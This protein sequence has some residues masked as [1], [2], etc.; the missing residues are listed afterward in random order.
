MADDRAQE[1]PGIAVHGIVGGVAVVD[2]AMDRHGAVGADG[3]AVQE[4]FQ[5]RTMVFAVAEGDA[6]RA[7]GG[8]GGGLAG[9]V[10]AEADGGG[11]L[12]QLLQVEL[13]GA[14]GLHDQGRA[15]DGGPERL[16]ADAF[17]VLRD[18]ITAGSSARIDRTV[19]A[20]PSRYTS[21]QRS[22]LLEVALPGSTV[23]RRIVFSE[24]V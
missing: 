10:A 1:R 21:R 3:D 16:L 14:D 8:V 18:R 20:V 13:E 4:L 15:L 9:V 11:I 5:I 19:I 22:A 23:A 6:R 24:S 7:F 12:M 17:G 2:L